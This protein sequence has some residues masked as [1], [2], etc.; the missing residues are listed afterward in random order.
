MN[1]LKVL[2]SALQ[3][4]LDQPTA[5]DAIRAFREALCAAADKDRATGDGRLTPPECQPTYASCWGSRP[6]WR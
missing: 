2:S 1:P 3:R 5:C 4:F 6:L